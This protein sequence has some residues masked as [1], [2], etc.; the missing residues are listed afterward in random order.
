ML[1]EEE[2]KYAL[3]E[4]NKIVDN[5]D[6][7]CAD[8]MRIAEAGDEAE[9]ALYEEIAKGGCCGSMDTEVFYRP[10]HKRIKIG[11]NYGH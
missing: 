1:S 11:C 9:E 5:E 10:T 4:L 2:K 3:D 8:S 7:E 6:L